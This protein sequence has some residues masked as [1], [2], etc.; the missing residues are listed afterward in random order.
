MVRKL[1]EVFCLS[2]DSTDYNEW[3]ELLISTV[4]RG[5]VA[6]L[7]EKTSEFEENLQV[8]ESLCVSP[9]IVLFTSGS[10]GK[11]KPVFHSWSALMMRPKAQPFD[12]LC[13][14]PPFKMA[15]LQVALHSYIAGGAVL[16][17]NIKTF[18]GNLVGDAVAL[19]PSMVPLFL[20]RCETT[21]IDDSVNVISM[22]GEPASAAALNSLKARFPRADVVHI[23]ASTEAGVMAT[24]K[25]GKPGLPSFLFEGKSPRFKVLPDGEL[26]FCDS[27]G[28]EYR[29]GDL[30]RVKNDR[31][32]FNGRV[33]D[34]Q[35]KVGGNFASISA[36]ESEIRE[37]DGVLG[38]RIVMSS[39]S[40]I[41]T[42]LTAEVVLDTQKGSL[43]RLR[44]HF[45]GRQIHERPHRFIE[46]QFLPTNDSGKMVR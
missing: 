36:L 5:G 1:P 42:L 32:Y 27:N 43:Q 29:T 34:S 31:H 46:V 6:V 12:W 4:T 15:G 14:Y 26:V 9:G 35:V 19:T 30:V 3:Y 20:S 41:Q 33:C 17:A 40:T 13:F 18:E 45:A 44:T 24:V 7:V 10:T 37:L 23:Y 2:G 8:I 16:Y 25:D 22:G 39:S 28:L 38:C 21:H 11:P